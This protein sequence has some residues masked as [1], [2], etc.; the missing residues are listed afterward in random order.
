MPNI[1]YRF[2]ES[3]N[4]IKLMKHN[5]QNNYNSSS[6]LN[7]GN[8]RYSSPVFENQQFDNS[9]FNTQK[10]NSINNK[11]RFDLDLNNSIGIIR[12]FKSINL[13]K[14]S[15]KLKSHL[16]KDNDKSFKL[17]FN[18]DKLDPFFAR[19]PLRSKKNTSNYFNA[20]D[21]IKNIYRSKE[22]KENDEKNKIRLVD[23][24]YYDKKKW[25]ERQKPKQEK[26]LQN[27]L[28]RKNTFSYLNEMLGEW[29]SKGKIKK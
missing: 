15:L 24:F 28:I 3:E 11:N 19:F 17:K 4:K 16:K 18:S 26:S 27:I 8:L 7:K 22:S 10:C 20:S 14:N 21:K 2:P 12:N 9:E 25:E 29:G 6:F 1:N 23:I 5:E 13:E